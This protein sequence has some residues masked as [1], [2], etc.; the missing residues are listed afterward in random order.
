MKQVISQRRVVNDDWHSV[1]DE[2][3]IDQLP[4]GKL[5]VPLSLWNAHR[6]TLSQRSEPLAVRL[7]PDDEVDALAPDLSRFA[8][9]VLQ[10]PS[11]R[12]GRAYS[13]ARSLRLHHDYQGDIRATG[14]VL[15]DQLMYMERVGFSSF[16]IDPKQRIED[17][18]KAFDE[19]KVKYQGS[20]DEPRALYQRR[21]A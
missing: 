10:F 9:V 14:N 12:D 13:Q 1:D 15:R 16:E 8:M 7:N 21:T 5:I 19:I 6:D 4:A 11:F 17:A 20:S 2:T 3:S 18:L